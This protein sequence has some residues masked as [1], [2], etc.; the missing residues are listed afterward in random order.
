M[1][2]RKMKSPRERSPRWQLDIVPSRL[3]RRDILLRFPD[4]GRRYWPGWNAD[5]DWLLKRGYLRI[6]R[7]RMS[8]TQNMNV[9]YITPKAL[10]YIVR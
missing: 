2:L 7:E 8:R 3:R 10:E 1:A 5:I 9:A 6:R 4:T